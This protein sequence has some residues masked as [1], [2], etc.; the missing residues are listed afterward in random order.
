MRSAATVGGH[1]R[2][3]ADATASGA[4]SFTG[5]ASD[6]VVAANT[7]IPSSPASV[8]LPP[9]T[10]L[11][12]ISGTG[13][14]PTNP[15]GLFPT[16]QASPAPSTAS[17]GLPSAKPGTVVHA[18]DAAATVPVDARLIGGQLAGLAVLAGAVTI[19]IARLSLR[20]PKP[21]DTANATPSKS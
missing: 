17:P 14:S 2:I 1:V 8:G 6:V 12:A 3:S 18:A 20:T 4:R 11:P 5:T 9:G 15:S 19:A 7:A 10:S 21:Q 16:V 13:V